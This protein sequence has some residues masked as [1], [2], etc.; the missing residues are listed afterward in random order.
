MALSEGPAGKDPEAFRTIREVSEQL[1]VPQH[2][3]RFW[4]TRFRELRP[5]KRGGNRRYYRPDDV[6][7]ALALKRLLHEQGYTVKGVQRLL[8]TRGVRATVEEVTGGAGAPA[9]EGRGAAAAPDPAGCAKP[10]EVAVPAEVTTRLRR[11]RDRLE[12]ALDAA[13]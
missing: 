1:G 2:V 9:N 8:A 3:L 12:A 7:L 11:I 5:L 6:A 10:C 13:A 4:E